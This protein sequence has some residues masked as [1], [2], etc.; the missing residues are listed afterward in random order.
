MSNPETNDL[1]LDTWAIDTPDGKSQ[2]VHVKA[3]SFA[4]VVPNPYARCLAALTFL[5]ASYV[6]GKG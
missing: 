1:K 6:S 4:I 2:L 5:D 3:R